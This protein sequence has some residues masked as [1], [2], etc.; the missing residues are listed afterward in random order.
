MMRRLV[1]PLLIVV[2]TAGLSATARFALGVPVPSGLWTI[3]ARTAIASGPTDTSRLLPDSL[4]HVTGGRDPFRVTRA[5]SIAR[6]DPRS[7]DRQA[8]AAPGPARPALVLVGI[9]IG[10]DSA[11]LLDGVP[12]FETT[13]VVHAG[14]HLGTLLIRAISADEVTIMSPDTT[15]ILRLR[16][17]FP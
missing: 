16:T 2:T 11:A 3:D 6:Y 10:T 13:R 4:G 9:L 7:D 5:S 8:S 15:W 14:E 17:H 1:Q 12:G